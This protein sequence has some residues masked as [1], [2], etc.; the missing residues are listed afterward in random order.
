MRAFFSILTALLLI[1][2]TVDNEAP[3]ADKAAAEEI[4]KRA[5]WK[6]PT[7]K[8]KILHAERREWTTNG[9]LQWHWFL[10]V[11]P[12]PELVKDLRDDNAFGL[13]ATN[14][15]TMLSKAPAWFD[16][17][18]ENADILRAPRG[19][20]HLVF[21]RKTNLL[22]AFDSGSGFR[23]GMSIPEAP[24]T[25]ASASTGRLPSTSPPLPTQ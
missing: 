23:P 6:R 14:T 19:N 22:H 16:C 4:F 5:F 12:S 10:V 2:C 9:V 25:A 18:S 17:P 20:T 13:V 21:S 15:L 7:S 1:G 8:D 3:F 24:Q 11:E